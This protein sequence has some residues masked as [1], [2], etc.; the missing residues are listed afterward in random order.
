MLN[1]G[2]GFLSPAS[3]PA[4]DAVR[5]SSIRIFSVWLLLV[6]YMADIFGVALACYIC[7]KHVLRPSLCI[8]S[9]TCSMVVP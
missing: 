2:I 6:I 7:T 5:F 1:L 4:V 9:L 8:S 3:D